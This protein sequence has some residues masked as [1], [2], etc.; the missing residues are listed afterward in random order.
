[1]LR[2]MVFLRMDWGRDRS[3]VELFSLNFLKNSMKIRQFLNIFGNFEGSYTGVFSVYG[4]FVHLTV[5]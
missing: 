4:C 1:M 2:Q 3:V 5:S